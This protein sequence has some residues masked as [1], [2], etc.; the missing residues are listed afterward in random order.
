MVHGGGDVEGTVLDRGHDQ[1]AG[2][3]QRGARHLLVPGPDDHLVDAPYGG[4][5]GLAEA[6]R[7]A[8][9]VLQLKR[10]VL[11][12]VAGPRT[13]LEPL[14]EAAALANAAAMLDQRREPGRQAF[15]E[16]RDLVGGEILQFADINPC[17]Q[18]RPIC[19]HIRAAQR[20]DIEN[21]NVLLFH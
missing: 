20:H 16:P 3:E 21:L 8:G 14:Q 6:A 2:G 18:H 4:L 13:F 17:L 15:V 7:H 12:D 9:Q 1:V 5:A 10:H 19:P 11:E